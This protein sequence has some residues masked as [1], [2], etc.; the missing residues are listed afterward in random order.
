M[1]KISV[2]IITLNEEKNIGRC[3]RSVKPIADEIVVVDSCSTD[4]TKRICEEH[5]VCYYEQ[6]FYGY[7]LQK[8]YATQ[9]ARFDHILSLDA[10]E[11]LSEELQSSVREAKNNWDKDYYIMNRMTNFCGQWIRHGEWF[12]DPVIRLFDRRKATWTSRKIHEKVMPREFQQ[13]GFLKGYLL[14]YSYPSFSQYLR[15]TSK[16]AEMAA[17]ELYRRGFHPGLYHFYIKPFYRFFI[18][19]VIRRGFLDGY[20]GYYIA[21]LTAFRLFLKFTKLKEMYEQKE[22]PYADISL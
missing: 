10:D 17:W 14:H 18:A 4:Q 11:E 8:I 6:T 7:G 12:P 15:K 20:T 19:F 22:Y 13:A 16:Y 2:V 5:K 9:R 21:R 1:V 3:L